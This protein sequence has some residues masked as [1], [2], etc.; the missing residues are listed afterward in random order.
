MFPHDDPDRPVTV[1]R[2]NDSGVLA[3]AK[4]VLDDAGIEF[5]VVG[6]TVGGLYPGPGVGPYI[7]EIR[8]AAACAVEARELLNELE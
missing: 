8:V 5:F 1:L 2:T 7:P 3:V 4:S 6:E